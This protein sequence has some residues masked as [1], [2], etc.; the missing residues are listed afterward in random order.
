MPCNVFTM[1]SALVI[2]HF[3]VSLNSTILSDTD[4]EE[5]SNC[6]SEMQHVKSFVHWANFQK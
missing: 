6:D 4:I 3:M 5:V 2:I 1:A